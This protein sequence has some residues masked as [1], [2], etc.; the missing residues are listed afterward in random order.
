MTL[1]RFALIVLCAALPA[2]AQNPI[3]D[4]ERFLY[5]LVK[6]NIVKTAEK[7]PEDLYS[8]KPAPEV[9]TMAQML[10]HVADANY[11]FC[12][13]VLGEK[14]P[15]PGVEKTMST[16]AEIVPA[17]KAAFAYCDKA[18]EQMTD[19]EAVK[20]IKFFGREMSKATVLGFN[21]FHTMEHYGNL[22]TYMRIKGI[23]PP[24]SEGR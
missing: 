9:K 15:S 23:V 8:F 19:A 18:Y 22:V 14:A 6:G 12:A 24:S 5:N 1:R 7:V 10:G 3:S 21:S 20:V 4:G 16:K 17:V 13:A 2:A 11:M